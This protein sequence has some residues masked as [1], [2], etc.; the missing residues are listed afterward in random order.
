MSQTRQRGNDT[1]IECGSTEIEGSVIDITDNGAEQEMYCN[2]CE[3]DYIDVYTFSHSV[4]IYKE[5]K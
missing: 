3:A 5:I 2:T 4:C 1:C